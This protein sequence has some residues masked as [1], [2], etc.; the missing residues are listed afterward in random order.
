MFKNS[1]LYNISITGIT[2]LDYYPSKKCI[3]N[4]K[5]NIYTVDVCIPCKKPDVEDIEEIKA[6]MCT[7][8]CKLIDTILGPKIVFNGITNIKVI[9]TANNDEQS[10]HSAHWNIPFCDFILIDNM[11][12]KEFNM[13]SL[14]LFIGIEDICINCYDERYINLSIIFIACLTLNKPQD[15]CHCSKCS[16]DNCPEDKWDNNYKDSNCEKGNSNTYYCKV[17]HY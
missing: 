11:C 12:N 3:I 1:R 15:N 9:Y 8:K 16:K 14:N 17:E 4:C 10:L 7:T 6:T 2:P 13:N 5:Q